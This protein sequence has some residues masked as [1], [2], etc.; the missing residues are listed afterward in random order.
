LKR[1]I[2]I[3]LPQINADFADNKICVHLRNLR[4]NWPL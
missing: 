3:L 2:R 1:T 4:L